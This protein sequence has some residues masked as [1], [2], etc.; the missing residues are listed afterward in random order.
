VHD[1]F[2]DLGSVTVPSGVLVFGLAG[3]VDYWPSTGVRLAARAKAAAASGGGHLLDPDCEAVAVPV[4]ADRPLTVRASTSASPFDGEPTI[5]ILEVDL[6]VPWES[7]GTTGNVKL[8]DLPVD[9]CGMV[10]GDAEALDGFVGLG[11]D[12]TDGLADLS[13]WGRHSDL[14]Q[15]VFGGERTGSPG[16]A[17][18][19]LDLPLAEA[20]SMADDMRAW[21]DA[22]NGG[23]G[24]MVDI[25]EHTD[26]SRMCRAG[27]D[28][29]L[30][31]GLI[32]VEGCR[33]LGFQW[34]PGDHS[35]RHRGERAAGQVYAVT[36][37]P[38]AA[39]GTVLR[40]TIPPAQTVN[41]EC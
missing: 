40:W 35:M 7:A 33:V 28:H 9:R 12:S 20:E 14:A 11:A 27:W 32:E 8:G 23:I 18:G 2:T 29:P 10:L 16:G 1:A 15:A 31:V 19:W 25:E 26:Y 4:A 5:A 24:L 37:E 39:G 22:T 6:G 17:R 41:A 38:D 13:Y 36:L 34:H 3:W 21:N 30:L